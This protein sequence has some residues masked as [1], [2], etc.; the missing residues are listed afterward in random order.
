VSKRAAQTAQI[1][2]LADERGW[3]PLRLQLGVQSFGI[4]GWTAREA[5]AKVIQEHD[6]VSSGHEELY[7]VTTGHAVFTVDGEEIDAPAGTVVFV[8]EPESKRTAIARDAATT[9]VA[10]GGVPGEVYRPRAW[11]T[12]FDVLDLFEQGD[13]AGAKR[14]L[15]QALD[16][17]SDHELLHYNLACAEAQLGETDSALDHL[18][19][20]IQ[21]RPRFVDDARNDPDLAS[22]HGLERFAQ[23]VGEA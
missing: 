8:P 6:E 3:A 22:L 13:H 1:A 21:Q 7:I 18:A 9:V 19:A 10:I 14:V 11:E 20:A 2:D 16:T 12:N 23:L 15:T 4:N 17:Y 5:G